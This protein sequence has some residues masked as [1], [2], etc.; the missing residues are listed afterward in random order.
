MFLKMTRI[1]N[2]IAFT[3][4]GIMIHVRS[5]AST[6][7]DIMIYVHSVVEAL[8]PLELIQLIYAINVM[9]INMSTN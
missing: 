8:V 7:A 1:H 6:S 9:I 4:V 2:I 3:S 5:S